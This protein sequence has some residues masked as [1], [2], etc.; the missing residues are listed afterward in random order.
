MDGDNFFIWF[1]EIF[2]PFTD[3]ITGPNLLFLDG[4]DSHFSV[5]LFELAREKNIHVFFFPGHSSHKLQPLDVGIF[6]SVKTAWKETLNNYFWTN[7][8]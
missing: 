7:E 6:K 1:R 3:E 8:Y 4:H 2:V 5:R